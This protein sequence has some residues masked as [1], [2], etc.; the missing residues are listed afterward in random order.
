MYHQ[1]PGISNVFF[2]TLDKLKLKFSSM[3]IVKVTQNVFNFTRGVV[4]MKE[5]KSHNIS[6]H[7]NIRVTH[8]SY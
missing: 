4:N 8:I 7:F 5:E 1:I 6:I 2:Q 3:T